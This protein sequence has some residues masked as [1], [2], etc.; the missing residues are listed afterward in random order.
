MIDHSRTRAVLCNGTIHWQ[1]LLQPM[2]QLRQ[3]HN[4]TWLP[5]RNF[6]PMFPSKSRL[7]DYCYQ[8]L[9]KKRKKERN[10]KEKPL[11]FSNEILNLVILK[12]C[13]RLMIL[14]TAITPQSVWEKER[15]ITKS[16]KRCE[17]L[18]RHC[19]LILL[20]LPLPATRLTNYALPPL[21]AF[22]FTLHVEP[23]STSYL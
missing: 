3:I 17:L 14:L 12:G 18:P 6:F 10:C 23:S 16:V 11:S 7:L 13:V 4:Y 2:V 9:E 20:Q 19:A 1:T 15:H 21:S 22:I 8:F 5:C